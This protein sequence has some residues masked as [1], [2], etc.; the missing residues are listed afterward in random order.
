M[1]V[2][3]Y[4]DVCNCGEMHVGQAGRQI[5]RKRAQTTT[6]DPVV[7]AVIIAAVTAE[8]VKQSVMVLEN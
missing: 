4:L 7:V 8:A 5:S 6:E 2:D 3:G 1:R